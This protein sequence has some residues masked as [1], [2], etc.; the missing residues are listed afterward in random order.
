L[1]DGFDFGEFGHG[2]C[3]GVFGEAASSK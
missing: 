1:A 3:V 2:G